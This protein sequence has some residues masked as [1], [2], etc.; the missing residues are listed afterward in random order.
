MSKLFAVALGAA[1]LLSAPLGFAG[2]GDPDPDFGNGGVA[3]L[4][5]DGIEG[6]E[7]R[8]KTVIALAGGKLLFAGSR[9]LLIPGNPDPAMRAMMA[10]MNPDGSPDLGFGADPNNPGILVLPS[11]S[12]TA[13]QTI[14][15]MRTL[16]DGTI[17]VAGYAYVFGPLSG[18]IGKFDADGHPDD[19]FGQDGILQIPSV[20]LHAMAIDSQGRIVV[21]GEQ[22]INGLSQ[23]YIARLSTDG[24]FDP[25]FGPVDDGTVLLTPEVAGDNAY[26][27]A[28]ALD[29]ADGIVAGGIYEDNQNFLSQFSLAHVDADGNLVTTFADDGWRRFT[30]PGDTSMFNG[31]DVLTR[32]PDGLI[33]IGAHHDDGQGGTV[34]VL[35]QL[36]AN[37]NDDA[38][39]GDPSTPG[40]R[41]LVVVPDAWNRYASAVVRQD[42]GKFLVSVSYATPAKE[43]FVVARVGT[44][45]APDPDFGT[46]GIV[47]F[48]A[49]P[50]GVYSNLTAMT[51]Q[52]G[53]PILAGSAMRD[54]G[55]SLVDLAAVRLENGP[56][57]DDLI[58][59]NGFDGTSTAPSVSTYDDLAEG[60]LGTDYTYNGIYYHDA[61]GIGGIFPDGSTF[62]ADDVG[63]Q[64]II[65]DAGVLWNDFPDFGSFPNVLTFGTAYIPGDNFSIGALVQAS[66]DL[67]GPANAV[68]MDL[69]FYENGPWGG[70]ELHLDAFLGDTLVGSDSLTIANGGGR[71][72]VTTTTF[73]IDGVT[74]DKLRLY[75]TYDGQP[76]APRVMID[77]L[78]LTPAPS[79]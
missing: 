73:S 17:L 41:N 46:A 28:I 71:D 26:I 59:A 68:S 31:I 6:H 48:D 56:A 23:G 7:L 15:A 2:D 13:I 4:A 35:G 32:T 22:S 20:F 69:A 19:A 18:F 40:Y 77:D 29:D 49:A 45:G 39:F 12:A 33:V 37:G 3:Y 53:K 62:T 74:F 9:N 10:R 58:F 50:G 75:A 27:S 76:S 54:P 8:A 79:R 55:S 36:D 64:F 1:T 24:T 61:N 30:V 57:G 11:I 70:I 21:A 72:D 63:D 47:D 42:D 5:L 25:T 65:E 43:D 38:A 60:F 78:A 16:D 52:D 67:P 14:E 51:L 66:M 34:V 44:D